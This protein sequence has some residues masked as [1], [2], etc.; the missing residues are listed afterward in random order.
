M[1]RHVLFDFDGTIVDSMAVAARLINLAAAKYK[2]RPIGEEELTRLRALP[3]LE[4]FRALHIPMYKIPAM[5]IELMKRYQKHIASLCPFDGISEVLRELSQKGLSLSI[6]SSNSRS[7]V[8]EFLRR[9]DLDFFDSV[10]GISSLFGKDKAIGG[11]MRNHGLERNELV[12]VGDEHRDI[13][14]CKANGIPVVAVSW[15]YDPVELLAEAGPDFIASS[16]SEIVH[17]ITLAAS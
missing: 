10:H 16:P 12:Y 11:F 6:L 14:A 3:I 4:R 1:I 5:A 17:F 8:V 9:N 2:F 15:G 13:M 7:N